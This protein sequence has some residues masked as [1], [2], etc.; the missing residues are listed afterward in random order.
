MQLDL[1]PLNVLDDN[2]Y[3][4]DDTY[5]TDT[6]IRTSPKR[7]DDND[8]Q[9]N[10]DRT[11]ALFNSNRSSTSAVVKNNADLGGDT[12]EF[13]TENIPPERDV[14]PAK[15]A[16]RLLSAV[17]V[18]T[19]KDGK[20]CK[21][22]DRQ[23]E[24]RFRLQQHMKK[25]SFTNHRCNICN[26]NF[27][28]KSTLKRHSEMHTAGSKSH[29]CD[30]CGKRFSRADHLKLHMNM[31]TGENLIECEFCGK[32]FARK[33]NLDRHR[34]IHTKEKVYKCNICNKNF[35]D[36]STF[37]RHAVIHTREILYQNRSTLREKNLD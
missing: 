23:Y 20:E 6:S 14:E 29:K 33:D 26:K 19:G 31:H 3:I 17:D 16:T 36:T 27:R 11:V 25:H 1:A 34:N 18:S 2:R 5:D 13:S 10:G 24:N 4:A 21:V 12:E 28:T 37:R 32:K 9:E 7:T 35:N 30:D 8:T 22:C 15:E